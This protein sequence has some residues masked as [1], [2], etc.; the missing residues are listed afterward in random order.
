MSGGEGE[1]GKEEAR[2]A[3]VVVM[4]VY[5]PM[6]DNDRDK[7]GLAL[8]RLQYKMNFYKLLESRCSALERAGKCV[9]IRSKRGRLLLSS[10]FY[11]LVLAVGDFNC[12]REALDS[13]YML[14]DP[15]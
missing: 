3:V 1:E 2:S 14:D 10:F 13:A 8:S 7:E 6:Y 5:C 15:V 4:N 12:S 11:R 9:A